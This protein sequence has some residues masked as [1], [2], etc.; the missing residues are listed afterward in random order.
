ML[1]GRQGNFV[2]G[3]RYSKRTVF[4]LIVVLLNFRKY[5]STVSV[6]KIVIAAFFGFCF[7][8]VQRF[9]LSIDGVNVFFVIVLVSFFL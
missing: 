2:S 3:V 1:N 6:R 4:S 5:L 7:R 8:F 9:K